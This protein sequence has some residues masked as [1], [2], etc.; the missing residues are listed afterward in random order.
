M[1]MT[2][3]AGW[4]HLR[5]PDQVEEHGGNPAADAVLQEG[6]ANEQTPP[7]SHAGPTVPDERTSETFVGG[8]GI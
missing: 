8:A 2:L 5:E 3:S 4:H 7:H 1:Q 6:C